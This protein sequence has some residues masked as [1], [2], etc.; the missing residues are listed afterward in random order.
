MQGCFLLFFVYFSW[1]ASRLRIIVC[2]RD[3][4][5]GS[6]LFKDSFHPSQPHYP[7]MGPRNHQKF[8]KCVSQLTCRTTTALV[9]MSMLPCA[10]WAVVTLESG[11]TC[12][13]AESSTATN[14]PT[15]SL[16]LSLSLSHSSHSLTHSTKMLRPW[17]RF[18]SHQTVG[19]NLQTDPNWFTRT[20]TF[21]GSHGLNSLPFFYK[22]MSVQN[23]RCVTLWPCHLH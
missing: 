23:N 3:E 9:I 16:S 11:A 17:T 6:V 15:H 22:M 7:K 4:M 5:S 18:S 1:S 19:E 13:I 20:Y 10:R 8:N 14:Q 21:L 2:S 12:N